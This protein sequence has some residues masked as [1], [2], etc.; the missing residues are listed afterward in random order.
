MTEGAAPATSREAAE[1]NA[2]AVMVGD[3]A[4]VMA[5]VTPQA[6][7]QLMSLGSGGMSPSALPSITGY[8]VQEQPADEAEGDLFHVR[9]D[10]PQGTATIAARWKQVLG[11][12]KITEVSLVQAEES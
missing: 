7:Q 2:R 3:L 10:S 9:F 1:R 6:L 12:W 11:Q 4:Q 5:D 8:E